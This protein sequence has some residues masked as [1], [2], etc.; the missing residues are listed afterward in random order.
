MGRKSTVK[1]NPENLRRQSSGAVLVL[2]SCG[3][4]A[5]S[6]GTDDLSGPQIPE[7]PVDQG[8]EPAV[9]CSEG[10]SGHGAL[11]RICFPDEWNGDLVLYAH[12]YVAP[13]RELAIPEES[14]EGQPSSSLITGMGYA[15]ATT[16]YRANGLVAPVAV[17]DLIELVD[18]IQQRYRPD[19]SRTVV[20]GFSE[21][22]LVATLAVERHPNRFQGA[23]AG[24]GPIGDIRAQLDYID[25]FR[26]VFDY[27][28]PGVLP[29]N[30]LEIPESIRDRW[31][32]LYVPAIVLA[33]AAKPAAARDLLSVTEAPV[34]GDDIRS[35]AE[36]SVGLLWYNVFGTADAQARLGGQPF[37]NSNRVYSGSTDDAALNAGIERFHANPVALEGLV[38]FS[39]SGELRV[40]LINLHTT[41]DPIVP[42]GQASLYA[43]KV[44]RTGTT[45]RFSQIDVDRH[46]H[47]TFQSAELLGAFSE[48]WEKVGRQ[49]AS[50]PGLQASR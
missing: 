47:C 38:D 13:Q 43:D 29:G 46:G 42:F 14:V 4:L 1:W 50:A 6:S 49:P 16:S 18:T 31:D 17:D 12:G 20:V 32:L 22:G 15:Y 26:V 25:D 41:G 3:A 34:A 8:Q 2:L 45:S 35:V 21:G 28:F 23:L 19:P 39:T 44:A 24:C 37:D 7:P 30:A 40:P 10:V 11:F 36:T 48:L 9:G 5:C 33:L 27:F